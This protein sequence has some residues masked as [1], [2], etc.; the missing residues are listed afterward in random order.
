VTPAAQDGGLVIGF[1][2]PDAELAGTGWRIDA[3]EGGLLLVDGDAHAAD[4]ELEEV[5]EE[6]ARARLVAA[7]ASCELMLEPRLGTLALARADGSPPPGGALSAALC[8]A[9]VEIGGERP[10]GGRE[11]AGYLSGWGLE[12]ETTSARHLTAIDADGSLL[13]LAANRPA[14]ASG[15]GEEDVAA[16]TVDAEGHV[17]AFGEALLS[18]QYDAHDAVTRAGLELWP[19]GDP[20]APVRVTGTR[21]GGSETGAIAATLMRF[22]VDG[23]PALGSYLIHR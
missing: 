13:L 6:L 10:V 4:L 18:T 23:R 15:H 17:T 19:P 1:A 21:L 8:S 5:G 20:A 9:H 12:P 7:A 22:A 14:H 11:C 2:D 3:S 16:W